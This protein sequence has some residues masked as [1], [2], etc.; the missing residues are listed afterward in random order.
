[1]TAQPGELE[2]A[3]RADRP[4]AVIVPLGQTGLVG[5]VRQTLEERARLR[6]LAVGVRD[7]RSVLFEMRPVRSEWGDVAPDELP[8]LLRAALAA[9]VTF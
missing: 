6:V 7:G 4:D 9:D 1:M 3:L 8:A 2:A 5:E